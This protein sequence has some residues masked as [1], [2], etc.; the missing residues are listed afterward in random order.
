[1]VLVK[2]DLKTGARLDLSDGGVIW[3]EPCASDLM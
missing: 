2:R 3:H 1:M